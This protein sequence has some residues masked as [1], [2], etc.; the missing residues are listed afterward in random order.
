[1]QRLAYYQVSTTMTTKHADLSEL[2]RFADPSQLIL[3]SL[4]SR[5]K[6]G[7]AMTQDIAAMTGVRLG[8]GTLYG[9]LVQLEQRRLIAPLLAEERRRPYWLTGLGAA[10]LCEQLTRLA[11]VA[12]TGLARL[13]TSLDT[14]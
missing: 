3:T 1:M 2:G 13:A 9:A 5:P 8:P 12:A 6:H 14:A 7:H 11:S 4:A 10:A